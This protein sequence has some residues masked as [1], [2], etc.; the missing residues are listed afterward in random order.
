MN[1]QFLSAKRIGLA[2]SDGG[3]SETRLLMDPVGPKVRLQLEKG[4]GLDEL[5]LECMTTRDQLTCYHHIWDMDVGPISSSKVLQ[6][7]ATIER[8][9]SCFFY[10]YVPGMLPS[11]AVEL[12]HREADR[13]EAR[14]DR[15]AAAHEAHEDRSWMR[16]A[17]YVAIIGLALTFLLNL[18][19]YFWPRQGPP[20][21]NTHTPP[22]SEKPVLPSSP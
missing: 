8:A 15:E 10:P 1:C 17:V 22:P 14:K 2:I 21:P 7:M 12:E 9:E 5:I 3:A 4:R 19:A 16:K 6:E 18:V 20:P 11:A 13:R